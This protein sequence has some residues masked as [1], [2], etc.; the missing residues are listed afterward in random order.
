ML[1]TLL[2]Q[3]IQ[4]P[5]KGTG[6]VIRFCDGDIDLEIATGTMPERVMALMQKIREPMTA[7]EIARG[8]GSNTSQVSTAL[9]RLVN[10]GEVSFISIEGCHKEYVLSS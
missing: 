4:P 10:S 5:K 1:G 6:R 7:S 2:F 3:R 8:T 9:K